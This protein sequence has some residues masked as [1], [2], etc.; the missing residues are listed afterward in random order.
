MAIEL[1]NRII[2]D[3][4]AQAKA[5]GEQIDQPLDSGSQNHLPKQ[6][7]EGGDR[8]IYLRNGL[9]IC[10]RQCQLWQTVR[11]AKQH[12][13]NF[14]VTAKFYLSGGSRVR[15]LDATDIAT[16]YEEIKGCHYLYHLPNHTEVEEWPADEP[17]HVVYICAEPSYFR[18][19]DAGKM[20]L[21]TSLRQLLEG[22][23]TQRFHQPLGQMTPPI[24]QAIQQILYCPYTGVM[25]Q[26]YLESKALE[27]FATQ[28]S[29]WTDTPSPQTSMALS[30]QDIEQLHQAKAILID[31]ATQPPSLIELARQVGLNDCKLK[32]GF[33]QLF[34]TTA[35]G[36]LRDYRLQQAKELLQ[37]S[38]LTIA[39]VA[40]KVGYKSPEAFCNAFRRKFAISPKAYQLSQRA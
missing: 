1:T 30:T 6:L 24:W 39:S 8:R 29:L 16:E 11:H 40:A 34:G 10:I 23:E 26:I 13:S 25:Q 31:R 3:I 18:M 5:Q 2:K 20:A 32:Q 21:S 38:N 35:F 14:L 4:E 12:G 28:F 19:F 15:T 9:T 17:I 7:G 27:L 22:D 37:N 33:R 36:Y